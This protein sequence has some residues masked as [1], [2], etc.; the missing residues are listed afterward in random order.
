MNYTC[1]KHH[2]ADHYECYKGYVAYTEGNV[3]DYKIIT[4]PNTKFHFTII[5]NF[6]DFY[7]IKFSL[8]CNK[9]KVYHES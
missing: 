5:Q 3:K 2:N 4:V 8:K 1:I 7:H 6:F 9:V